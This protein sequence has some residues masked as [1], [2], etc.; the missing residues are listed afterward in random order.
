MSAAAGGSL[1]LHAAQH[2]GAEVVG[3]TLSGEQKAFMR[4]P[5]RANAASEDHVEIRTPGLPAKSTDGPFDAVGSMEMG[6]HVGQR[7]LSRLRRR[8][9]HGVLRPADGCWSSRC[10][11]AG[12]HP[13]GGP[14]IESFIAPDMHMRPVGETLA[15]L[16]D[17]GLEIEGVKGMRRDYV[18]TP[19]GLVREVGGQPRG[20][21]R[22]DGRGD[23]PGVAAVPRG[24]RCA[25]SPSA[26]WAWNRIPLQQ[27]GEAG[28]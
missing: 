28:R 27:A 6:E 10:P 19:R 12:K 7:E 15:L 3:V 8:A 11:G 4:R 17:A 22:D 18:R 20:R 25:V 2:Y 23:R 21:R 1:S 16:E 9:V 5:H 26:G 24:Q 14:F 13:G